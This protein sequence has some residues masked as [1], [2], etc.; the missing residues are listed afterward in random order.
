MSEI[1]MQK[2]LNTLW[3]FIG[4]KEDKYNLIQKA[5]KVCKIFKVK[6]L[7]TTRPDVPSKKA[8]FNLF[9]KYIPKTKKQLQMFLSI[10]QMQSYRRNGKSLK[11][12]T[13]R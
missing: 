10:R 4:G 7:K 6:T 11:P 1:N 3:E 2:F 5:F 12:A 8:G 9:C 13:R